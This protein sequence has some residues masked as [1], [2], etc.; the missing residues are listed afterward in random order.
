MFPLSDEN[1]TMVHNHT[2][3]DIRHQIKAEGLRDEAVLDG[4]LKAIESFLYSNET[5]AGY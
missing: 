2:F 3:K 4:D 1:V 5:Q